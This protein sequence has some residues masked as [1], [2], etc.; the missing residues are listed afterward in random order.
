MKVRVELPEQLDVDEHEDAHARDEIPDRSPYG[1]HHLAD[2]PDVEVEFRHPLHSTSAAWVARKVRNRLNGFEVVATAAEMLS[3]ERRTSDAVLCMSELTGFPAAL[4]PGGPPV[5]SNIV[6]AG[7]PETYSASKR[8]TVGRALHRLSGVVVLADSIGEDLVDAWDLDP[9]RVHSV[10]LGIDTDFFPAQPWEDAGPTV[11]SVGDDRFRDHPLLVDAVARLQARGVPVR[12]ELGT[13]QRDV[14]I[15]AS[16]GTLHRRRMEGDVRAMYGRA[17]V[18]AVALVPTMRGSGSTV[19]L[20]A[21]AS[22]RPIVATRTPPMEALIEHGVRGLLVEP[23]D[24]DAMADAIGELL[25]DP[26]RA[27]AMGEAARE[28]VVEH[29]TTAV[30]AADLREVLRAAVKQAA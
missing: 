29:H 10:R 19:V 16:L 14:R 23:G 6:W 8:V 21:A 4:A 30:M 1:L 2:D 28:W 26:G 13:T 24:P 3:R 5:V 20:E 17:T 7:R 18:V 15:P 27:R 12:L 11:A 9:E 25:A 22:A